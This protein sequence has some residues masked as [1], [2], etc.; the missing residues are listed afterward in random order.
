[1]RRGAV[2][3]VGGPDFFGV[4]KRGTSFFFQCAKEG[5]ARIFSQKCFAPSGGQIIF[6]KLRGGPNFFPVSKGGDQNFFTYEKGGTRKNWRPAITNRWPPLLV[7][8]NNSLMGMGV[9][10]CCCFFVLQQ[11]S[12]TCWDKSF[13]PVGTKVFHMLGAEVLRQTTLA[14]KRPTRG[15]L[16]EFTWFVQAGW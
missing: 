12:I 4:L 13:S 14:N 6:P 1:M 7:K 10:L 16:V 11:K 2:C 3:F 5:G 15:D 9:F 8:N